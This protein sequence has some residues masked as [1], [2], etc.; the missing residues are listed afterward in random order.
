MKYFTKTML[1]VLLVILLVTVACT[2]KPLPASKSQYETARQEAIEADEKVI[3]LE[4]EKAELEAE[5]QRRK[6]FEV[7]SMT[8]TVTR[9]AESNDEFVYLTDE[10]YRALGSCEKREYHEAL[11]EEMA[12]LLRR[13]TEATVTITYL[14]REIEELRRQ[15]L[16]LAEPEEKEEIIVTEVEP[17]PVVTPPPAR[18]ND[19]YIVKRGDW[20]SKIAAFDFIYGDWRKWPAIYEAN[21]EHIT[22][23]DLIYPDQELIIPRD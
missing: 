4:I 15:L 14:E 12:N 8:L 13:R 3:A 23:P 18:Q 6:G 22:N 16:A 1:V 5:I 9:T 20:L 7:E 19:R 17:E 10:E 2:P 11:A 21:K